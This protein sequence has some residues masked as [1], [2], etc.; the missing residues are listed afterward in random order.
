[1]QVDAQRQD[2]GNADDHEYRPDEPA[3]LRLFVLDKGNK[4][5]DEPN[6]ADIERAFDPK[7][8][9]KMLTDPLTQQEVI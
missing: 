2:E 8:T 3:V 9:V 6:Q 7:G 5:E 4:G 1:M